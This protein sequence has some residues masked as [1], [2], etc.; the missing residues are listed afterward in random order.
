MATRAHLVGSVP[1]RDEQ[2]VFR[3]TS[4]IL[5]RRLSKIPDGETG[6]RSDWIVWQMP[7]LQSSPQL[8]VVPPDPDHYRPL[9]RVKLREGRTAEQVELGSLGYADA[10]KASYGVFRR[11]RDQGVIATDC[12]FQVCLPTPLA[13]IGAFVMPGEDQAAL[14][15]VYRE[16]MLTELDEIVASIPHSEL[17]LQWDTAVEFGILEGVFPA[18]FDNTRESVIERLVLVGRRVPEDVPLGYHL[19]YGDA[20]HRHFTQPADA[21]MLVAVANGVMAGLDRPLAWIHMPVPRDRDDTAYFS[22]LSG[23]ERPEGTELFLGLIHN[24]DGLEGAQRR[25]KAASQV[26]ESFGVATECG[27]GR[28]PPE[29]IPDLLR[30]HEA[31]CQSL[32]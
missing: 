25:A 28:R 8:E 2:E 29:T 11:L 27:M 31:V 7:V 1:L 5:G 4:E 12:R 16:R 14:E 32:D 15:P 26:V 20:G 6:V 18:W 24:T 13:P 30:L 23:L 22:P 9:P 17:A 21:G 10:A 19:C 3:N